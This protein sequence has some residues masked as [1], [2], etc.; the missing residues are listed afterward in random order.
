[1]SAQHV[2]HPGGSAALVAPKGT[3]ARGLG[4]DS[5]GAPRLPGDMVTRNK[6]TCSP[7]RH[8]VQQHVGDSVLCSHAACG[9]CCFSSFLS[10]L[11]QATAGRHHTSG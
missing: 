5:K 10:V 3:P 4:H 2:E 1:M 11:L 9:G 7:E 6:G 8:R